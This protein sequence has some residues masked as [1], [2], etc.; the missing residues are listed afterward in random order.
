MNSE[1]KV[2]P[3][4]DLIKCRIFFSITYGS[5]YANYDQIFFIFGPTILPLK[6]AKL[7]KGKRLL[8]KT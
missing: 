2:H 5:I 1:K 8:K 4:E 7:K 3:Y 6:K